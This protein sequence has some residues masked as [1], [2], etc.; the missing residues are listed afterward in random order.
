MGRRDAIADALRPTDAPECDTVRDSPRLLMRIQMNR[1]SAMQAWTA[2]AKP[3]DG[4]HG[5][6]NQAATKAGTE[7]TKPYELT[8]EDCSAIDAY[9]ARNQAPRL[10]V[11]EKAG[12]VRHARAAIRGLRASLLG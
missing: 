8:P 5:M 6:A 11:T 2:I 12:A 10:K 7:L 3:T 4:A 1:N 9:F